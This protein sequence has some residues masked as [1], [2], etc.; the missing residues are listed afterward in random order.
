VVQD[1]FAHRYLAA[2]EAEHGSDPACRFFAGCLAHGDL[3]L[4]GVVDVLTVRCSVLSLGDFVAAQ[5][6]LGETK[7]THGGC[8]CWLLVVDGWMDRYDDMLL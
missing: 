4:V 3:E 2:P 6:F 5:R 8:C 1:L 7:E